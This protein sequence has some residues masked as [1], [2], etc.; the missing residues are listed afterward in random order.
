MVMIIA[1]AEHIARQWFMNVPK[2]EKHEMIESISYNDK[3][4]SAVCKKVQ[5]GWLKIW[6]WKLKQHKQFQMLK[7]TLWK[8]YV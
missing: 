7:K 4:T 8:N 6:L 2:E 5:K 3:L 1:A